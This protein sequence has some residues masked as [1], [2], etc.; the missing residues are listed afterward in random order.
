M[1]NVLTIA[2]SDSGGGAGIQADLETIAASGCH[3]SSVVAALTA[4]NT[5][6]VQ[7]V[8]EVS[9]RAIT[10]QIE[11]V[12]SD[13]GADAIKIGM[14]YSNGAV[15]AVAEA[16][17]S[18]ERPIPIVLD[19][20]ATATTGA[21]LLQPEARTILVEEL[22]PL[23]SVVTPNL[24]EAS[25]LT[26][27]EI[28]DVSGMKEAARAIQRQGPAAVIV[29]G[30]HLEGAPVDVLYDGADFVELSGERLDTGATHGSGCVFSAALA[31]ALARGDQLRSAFGYARGVVR[32]AMASG[33]TRRGV[34]GR[35]A[36]AL[37]P[38]QVLRDREQSSSV[39]GELVAAADRLARTGPGLLVPEVQSNF[40]YALPAAR[41]FE[42]V[43]GFPGRIIRVEE[44]VR[45]VS[46]PRFGAS[47]HI[48]RIVL[49]A[50]KTDPE[51]RSCLNVRYAPH[52]ERCAEELGFSAA[53][54]SRAD[55][56][57]D[58]REKE[59]SSLEYGTGTV[60]EGR[61]EVPDLIW[62]AGGDGKEPMIRVLGRSP[63]EVVDKAIRLAEV[64]F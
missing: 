11:S 53:S 59:G 20:V 61:T 56:P 51:V 13:L 60:L 28:S 49:T 44:E 34:P 64:M 27:M 52:V 50:M 8:F 14:L 3:G 10:A 31:S 46:L 4:Q 40:V 55:E 36:A 17:R 1:K 2:G 30:G 58:V 33:R 48:A 5:L 23:A 35:G 42:G 41:D 63:E 37:H 57:A 47:R 15:A 16:L 24:P 26:G 7:E 32:S 25:S 39:L 62:D 22:F 38:V 18:Q 43:A 19:P 6:G 45:V 54:F 12:L 29:K 21:E 9:P